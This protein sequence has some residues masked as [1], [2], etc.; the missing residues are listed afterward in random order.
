MN[1]GSVHVTNVYNRTVINNNYYNHVSFNGGPGGLAARPTRNE[2][3]FEH[4]RHFDPTPM[5]RQ[6]VSMAASNPQLRAA[7]NHGSPP[8]AATPRPGQFSGHGV[9]AARGFSGPHGGPV[10][11]QRPGAPGPVARNPAPIN[12]GPE[13]AH[14]E[15][16]RGGFSQPNAAGAPRPGNF[17][18]GVPHS[19]PA[20]QFGG[21]ASRPAGNFG[22]GAQHFNQPAQQHFSAPAPRPAGNFGGGAQRFSPPPQQHFSAPAPH[23]AG[24]FGGGRPPQNGGGGHR[25]EGHR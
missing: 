6:H 8:V 25:P 13:F 21:S 4:E 7:F 19:P 2:M 12:H 3:A 23:P 1:V 11:G 18:S 15:P 20:P 14:N 17:A 10:G 9:V 5:Q 22:G 16:S 24:N